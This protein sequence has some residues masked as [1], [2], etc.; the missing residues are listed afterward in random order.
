MINGNAGNDTITG[1]AG[2]DM[3]DPGTGVNVFKFAAGFGNDSINGFGATAARQ[4]KLDV[5]ALGI[6]SA[7]FGTR[8]TRAADATDTV[9]TVRNAD[10]TVAGTIRLISVAVGNVTAADFTLAP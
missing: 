8:V 5:S 7:N 10:G 3:L 2:D 9:V 4:D 1:G 6:T